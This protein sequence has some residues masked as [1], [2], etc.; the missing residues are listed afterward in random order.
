VSNRPFDDLSQPRIWLEALAFAATL[1]MREAGSVELVSSDVLQ[2][3]NSRNPFLHRRTWVSF[4][5][6]LAVKYQ[7]LNAS[8]H[9]R[10]EGLERQGLGSVDA[11]HLACAEKARAGYFITCDDRII[12][13][14]RGEALKVM[15]PVNFVINEVIDNDGDQDGY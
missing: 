11:L 7:E 10:A 5:L 2:F 4:Y 12:K 15:N 8:I 1:Q 3:E 6:S 14:Y 9:E 13:R